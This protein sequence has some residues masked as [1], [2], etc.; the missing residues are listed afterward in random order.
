MERILGSAGPGYRIIALAAAFSLGIAVSA[1]PDARA[2]EG[3][4]YM[5]LQIP[6]MFIDDTETKDTGAQAPA[7]GLP[8]TPYAAGANTEHKT[9]FKMAGLLGYEL[10]GGL[11]V[12]GELFFA[13][14][15]VDKLTYSGVS[16]RGQPLPGKIDVPTSGGADQLGATANVWFDIETGSDWVPFIGAGAGFVR[17]DQSGLKYNANA[18][19]ETIAAAGAQAATLQANP[20]ASEAEINGAV[21]LALAGL[22]PVPE[23][24]ETDTTLAYHFGVGV[25]YR[26]NDNT[27]LQFGY[28]LQFASDL[29]FSG[30]NANGSIESKTDLRVQFLEIGFRTRF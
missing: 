10:G 3:D 21:Q 22:P 17:V 5:G 20:N 13:R 4:W 16:A 12:E 26:L 30:S 6:V 1:A 19:A 28:R 2:A 7:P 29:E 8:Q 15:K 14:A 23:L 27:T 25:G 24:S 11:R 9:G 18:V